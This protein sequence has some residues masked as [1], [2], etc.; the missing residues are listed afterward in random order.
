MPKQELRRACVLSSHQLVAATFL[1]R[2][3]ARSLSMTMRQPVLSWGRCLYMEAVI[4]GM[5]GISELQN[6]KASPVHCARASSLKAK[7]CVEVSADS[8][9]AK[10]ST[11]PAWRILL[12]KEAVIFSSH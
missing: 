11:N 9:S 5:F 3:A 6:L 12:V 10:P 7:L 2:E 1:P 8:D 4:A